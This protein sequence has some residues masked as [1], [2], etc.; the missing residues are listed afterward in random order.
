MPEQ[1][2]TRNSELGTSTLLR[3]CIII[4]SEHHHL[5]MH[6][7][8]AVVKPKIAMKQVCAV[9]AIKQIGVVNVIM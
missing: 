1:T 7:T 6:H 9:D 5:C 2:S 4:L 8:K 3:Y